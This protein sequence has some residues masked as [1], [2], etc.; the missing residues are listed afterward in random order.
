MTNYCP[1][2]LQTLSNCHEIY[3]AQGHL[4]ILIQPL[5]KALARTCINVITNKQKRSKLWIQWILDATYDDIEQQQIEHYQQI[6][7]ILTTSTSQTTSTT[8]TTSTSTS[9]STSM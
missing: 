4:H 1:I 7:N 9:T 3:Q 6:Q 8:T 5:F 2:I